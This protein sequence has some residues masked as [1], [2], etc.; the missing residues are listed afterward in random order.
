[1]EEACLTHTYQVVVGFC[2]LQNIGNLVL[3]YLT[4]GEPSFEEWAEVWLHDGETSTPFTLETATGDGLIMVA[5]GSVTQQVE[6]WD[7]TRK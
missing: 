5:L 7:K 4:T 1:L 6:S 3:I 2:E